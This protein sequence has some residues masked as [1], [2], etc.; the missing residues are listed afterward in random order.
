MKSLELERL[1][2]E[3][4]SMIERRTALELF[5]DLAAEGFEHHLGNAAARVEPRQ[6]GYFNAIQI[7]PW[8]E[9][10]LYQVYAAPGQITTIALEPG[11][12]LA[13]TGP[14][15][16]GDTARW[17]I[18]DTESGPG[19]ETRVLVLVKPTRPDIRT[20]V[21]ISTDRRTYLIELNASE[22]TWMPAI[23]WAY[24]RVPDAPRIAP[25]TPRIPPAHERNHRYGLQGDSPPSLDEEDRLARALRDGALDTIN[26]AGQRIVQRQLEVPPT[27]TIRPGF[28]VRVIVTRDLVFAPP[29]G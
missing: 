26:E 22:E 4:Q 28:P 23:S 13:G 16:A 12:R 3:G 20:N 17:I 11:E 2:A 27:L 18:G 7:Y 6:A 1:V 24:P 15:A 14:I 25:A 29:G 8:S 19:R 5:R 21:V 10:A 9:G